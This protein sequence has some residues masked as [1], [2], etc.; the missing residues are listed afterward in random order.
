MIASYIYLENK[1]LS[2][3]WALVIYSLFHLIFLCMDEINAVLC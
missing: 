2:T 1:F 3:C